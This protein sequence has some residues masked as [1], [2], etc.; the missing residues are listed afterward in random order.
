M[1]KAVILF[2]AFF[3]CSPL[4]AFDPAGP[5][6]ERTMEWTTRSLANF[7]IPHVSL[8][9]MALIDALVFASRIDVPKAY[10]VS[11]E[12]PQAMERSDIRLTLEAKD[13]SWIE[14]LGIIAAKAN[15][16]LRI[17]PGLVTFVPRS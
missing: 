14:L 9:D 5:P 17:Q 2:C 3:T 13:I 7:K 15:L 1:S 6:P 11:L 8:K 12:Y 4:F 10:R 16:D